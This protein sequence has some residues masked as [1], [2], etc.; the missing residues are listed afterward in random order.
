MTLDDVV[1]IGDS[2]NDLPMLEI[3]GVGVA[4]SK[5]KKIEPGWGDPYQEEI[6]IS[7]D[8]LPD[9]ANMLRFAL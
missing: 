8:N 2:Y 9:F 7:F 4:V 1:A 6:I 3:A 5:Y